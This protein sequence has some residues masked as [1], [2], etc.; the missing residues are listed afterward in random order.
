MFYN[1]NNFSGTVLNSR[2]E[3]VFAIRIILLNFVSEEIALLKPE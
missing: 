3:F 2:V 1:I